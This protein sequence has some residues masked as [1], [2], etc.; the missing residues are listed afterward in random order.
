MQQEQEKRIDILHRQINE[1]DVKI[2]KQ[3]KLIQ[4]QAVELEQCRPQSELLRKLQ[5]SLCLAVF[6]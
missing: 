5:V 6:F 3:A 1:A 2:V 4:S